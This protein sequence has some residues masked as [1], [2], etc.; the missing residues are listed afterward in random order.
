MGQAW[1]ISGSPGCGKTHWIL[2]TFKNHKGSCAYLRLNGYSDIDL[3]DPTELKLLQKILK[4]KQ[5]LIQ[6]ALQ[7]LINIS[8]E[9]EN[10]MC[11]LKG[12]PQK[13]KLLKLLYNILLP[14][15]D[16]ILDINFPSFNN[17]TGRDTEGY[18]KY[19]VL[20]IVL[21][22]FVAVMLK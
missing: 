9:I 2:N 11:K 19:V 14:K 10:K 22:I 17:I 4:E 3:E 20:L 6:L 15:E 5:Q 8:V 21:L 13:S 7:N 12:I 18:I 16:I 1:L